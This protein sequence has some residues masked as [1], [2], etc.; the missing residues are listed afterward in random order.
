MRMINLVKIAFFEIEE[1]EKDYLTQKLQG[2]E[3]T[4]SEHP[5]TQETLYS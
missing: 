4:F 3:L 5:L 2:H 1:W